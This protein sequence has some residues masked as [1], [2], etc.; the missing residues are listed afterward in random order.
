MHHPDPDPNPGLTL[1]LTTA[2]RPQTLT[3]TLT[4]TP[5]KRLVFTGTPDVCFIID[6]K[7]WQWSKPGSGMTA[8]QL[9]AT[10]AAH[11][12][13]GHNVN[14]VQRAHHNGN[15]WFHGAKVQHVL[16]VDGMVICCV[17]SI[18]VHDARLYRESTIEAQL[19]TLYVV[20][21]DG[22]PNPF[23]PAMVLG[24]LAYPDTMHC[25]RQ[26][27]RAALAAIPNAAQRPAAELAQ[28][29]DQRIRGQVECSFQKVMS[30]NALNRD[31]TKFQLLRDGGVA[32]DHTQSIWHVEV[33]FANLHT[34]L[35]GRQVTGFLGVDPPTVTECLYSANN[36]FMVEV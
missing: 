17:S 35:Y 10:V 18:R 36:G 20:E 28:K 21:A 25:V 8:Q 9:A 34:C 11:A 33:L 19:S 29:K 5:R 6:G 27:S 30:L 16:E 23:R 7:A 22:N 2:K 3:L 14:L 31:Q 15:N 13:L 32:W 4:L 1:T 24:D 12:G 26:R